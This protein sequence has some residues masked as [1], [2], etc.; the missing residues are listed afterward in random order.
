MEIS[1]RKTVQS[2]IQA[3]MSF[4]AYERVI[5]GTLYR[6]VKHSNWLDETRN[7]GIKAYRLTRDEHGRISSE[8]VLSI[9]H[10]TSRRVV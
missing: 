5:N 10:D 2:G 3:S 7:K 4:V 8:L 6:F 1:G 9:G